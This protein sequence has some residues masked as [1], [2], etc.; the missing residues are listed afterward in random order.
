MAAAGPSS[1]ALHAPFPDASDPLSSV[2]AL[3]SSLD[4]STGDISAFLNALLPPCAAGPS[5]AP[6]LAPVDR[7]LSELLTRLSLLSQDTSSALEQAIHDVSRAVPRL[8]YDLQFMRESAGSLQSSLALVQARVQ[9]QS[10]ATSSVGGGGGGGGGAAGTDT[11]EARTRAALDRL[12]HLD[13][14]KTRM[15]SA[16][17]ILREAESWSTLE[18]EVAAHVAAGA[19]ARAADR[20]AE[21]GRSLVVFANTPGEYESRRALLVSLQNQLEAALS[22]ALKDALAAADSDA[23]ARFHRIFES[24]DRGTEFRAYYF[25]A[26]RAP[27]VDEWGGA[28]L[29]E[30]GQEGPT[31]ARFSAWLPKFYAVVLAT[32][33][34]ERAQVPLVFTAAAPAPVLAS[35]LQTT[36]DGLSPSLHDRLAAVVEWHGA[37]ALPELIRCLKATEDLAAAVRATLDK[38]EPAPAP[39]ETPTPALTPTA[40][41]GTGTGTRAQR[42]SLSFASASASTGTTLATTLDATLFEPFLGVQSSYASLERRY[43]SHLRTSDALLGNR[44]A[45]ALADRT[46]AAFA[47]ADDAVARCFAFTRGF[48]A[49][50]LVDALDAFLS[51]VIAETSL[52][53]APAA[54]PPARNGNGSGDDD[55]LDF[56]GLDYSTDDWAAF[57]L[58]LAALRACRLVRDR[59]GGFERSLHGTLRGI[60]TGGADGGASALLR[61]SAL[62]SAAL[63]AVIASPPALAAAAD[64]LAALTRDT[65]LALQQTILA[66]LRAALAGYPNLAVWA[67]PERARARGALAVPTFSLSP[68]DTVARV[69]EG[70]LNL[71]RVFEVVAADEALAFSLHTLPHVDAVPGL[72]AS[73][74]ATSTATSLAPDTQLPSDL[75]LS[76]WVSSL[77]LSLLATL[78]RHTLPAL[79]A[80]TAPGAAQ[81]AADLA[82]LGNAV[83]ALDVEWD[84]L[85]RWRAAAD[86][87]EAAFRDNRADKVWAT[88]GRLRG[89]A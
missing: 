86:A 60:D 7:A 11:D 28:M 56:D 63:A 39:A 66:P 69:A 44:S 30:N 20:L 36:L 4:S 19:W 75:V 85:E 5:R 88:V 43:L 76:T 18:G 50:G 71:L 9:R 73:V 15:E 83:R 27:V 59:L 58:G 51:A 65:Q 38:L 40:S 23:C 46:A 62:N 81:L 31:A 45:R 89:W 12:T 55:E 33:N 68:T 32:L 70:L 78:T 72:P 67:E 25:D 49:L 79:R 26:R 54:A 82:Y 6:D 35:F 64:A 34:A 74:T 47:M 61:D 22:A 57:Q 42:F 53:R 2:G 29:L 24:M 13:T 16:R 84:E 21:A 17:D 10:A 52:E 41:A 77:A 87:D 37:E 1:P 3:S 8:T 14:L 80:L 48:G